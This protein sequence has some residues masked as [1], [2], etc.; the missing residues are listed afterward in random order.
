M[1]RTTMKVGNVNITLSPSGI[2]TSV[3]VG[4]VRLRQKGK[5]TTA[6]MSLGNGLRWTKRIN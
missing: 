6:S 1:I 2:S 3:K 4:G 5:R